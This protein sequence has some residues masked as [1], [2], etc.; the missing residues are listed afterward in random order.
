MLIHD[1]VP[2]APTT[3]IINI[4][5]HY[6]YINKIHNPGVSLRFIPIYFPFRY[7]SNLSISFG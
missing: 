1:F 6:I 3:Y 5:I 7:L 4:S 2:P